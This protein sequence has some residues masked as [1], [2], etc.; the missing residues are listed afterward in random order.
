MNSSTTS[1]KGKPGS[2]NNY[3]ITKIIGYLALACVVVIIILFL[4]ETYTYYFASSGGISNSYL[5]QNSDR[6]LPG[7]T[8]PSPS[9]TKEGFDVQDA[10]DEVKMFPDIIDYIEKVE[11]PQFYNRSSIIG[12]YDNNDIIARTHPGNTCKSWYKN[13]S[14]IF[15]KPQSVNQVP[16]SPTDDN[17]N[18]YFNVEGKSYS[19]AELC[20]ETTNQKDPIACLYDRTQAFDLMSN[21]IS[22]INSDI[23]TQQDQRLG[24]LETD[25]SYHIID[26]N[27][28]YNQSQVRDFIGYERSLG[29]GTNILNG[30]TNDQLNDISVYAQKQRVNYLAGTSNPNSLA[31]PLPPLSEMDTMD[32]TGIEGGMNDESGLTAYSFEI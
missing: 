20:P 17:Y 24:N 25:A 23:Q 6:H 28:I 13:V 18:N 32:T 14:N 9:S 4:L 31:N 27:R 16:Q 11:E 21:K 10:K 19:F 5:E 26:G 7:S 30:T 8:V 29:L 12:C 15:F 3:D 1:T 2:N 22:K